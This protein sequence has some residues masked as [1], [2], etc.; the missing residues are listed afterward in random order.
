[1]HPEVVAP[2]IEKTISTESARRY[3]DFWGSRYDWVGF[4]ESRAKQRLFELLELAPGMKLLNVGLGS[5]LEHRRMIERLAAPQDAV[6]LDISSK[7][8]LSAQARGAAALVQAE[9][10]RLP[11]ASHT[12][13]RLYAAFVLDL[14][15]AVDLPGW[16]Q[17][18]GRV[19]R[20]GGRLVLGCLTEGNSP[21]SR[22][23]VS[24]WKAAYRFSPLACGGC[25][26]LQPAGLVQAA[27]F[28]LIHS[29]VIV[30]LGV[31][32]QVICAQL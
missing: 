17:A 19:L 11:F 8:L 31:P 23:L 32:S 1:M 20:P 2:P 30:Q 13:D 6:G 14:V 15:S 26:P 24:G 4:F 27:G 5:G 3:Y 25:R 9:G 29:E 18:F 7:M 10:Y 21:I 12:F 28:R 16:L 22:A